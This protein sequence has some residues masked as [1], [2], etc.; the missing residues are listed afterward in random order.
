MNFAHSLDD[1]HRVKYFP[2]VVIIVC[3]S[4]CVDSKGSQTKW[5]E[6]DD[7]LFFRDIGCNIC[8]IQN[9]EITKQSTILIPFFFFFL[10]I[11][12]NILSPSDRLAEPRLVPIRKVISFG[13][14]SL[15]APGISSELK[16]REWK[17]SPCF[18]TEA[19]ILPLDHS[20]SRSGLAWWGLNFRCIHLLSL[21]HCSLFLL[22]FPCPILAWSAD[23]TSYLLTCFWTTR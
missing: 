11:K 1:L 14:F 15:S 23:R 21:G 12:R 2:T 18:P 6:P 3:S 7:P 9:T 17:W 16:F 5:Q 10:M 22:L 13:V 19:W 20:Q 8:N 4:Q